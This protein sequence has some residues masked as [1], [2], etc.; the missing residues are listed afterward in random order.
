[1]LSFDEPRGRRRAVKPLLTAIETMI[2]SL[3]PR[4]SMLTELMAYQG[5]R[6]GEALALAD[7]SIRDRTLLVESNISLGEEKDTKTHRFLTV[8]FLRPVPQDLAAYR[9]GTRRDRVAGCPLLFP[10]ADGNP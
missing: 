2:A 10:R 5:L 4:D 1:M 6:P 7:S 3:P 8:N 9:L